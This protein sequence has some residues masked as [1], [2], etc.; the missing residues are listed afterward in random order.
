MISTMLAMVV[1]DT[2]PLSPPQ[3]DPSSSPSSLSDS[4][5]LSLLMFF[6]SFLL[7]FAGQK[8]LRPSLTTASTLLAAYTT[9]LLLLAYPLS[10]PSSLS[11]LLV[12]S[13]GLAGAVASL[14]LVEIGIILMGI[15]FGL[16]M[17]SLSYHLFHQW[18]AIQDH[19]EVIRLL[20]MI[21]LALASAMVS[22]FCLRPVLKFITAFIGSYF[23]VASIS[24]FLYRI[25]LFPLESF[26]PEHFFSSPSNFQCLHGDT[27]VLSICYGYGVVWVIL[28]VTGLVFQCSE[29]R[30]KYDQYEDIRLIQ[31]RHRERNNEREALAEERL[32]LMVE[33][34]RKGQNQYG[35]N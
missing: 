32:G 25:G 22:L 8:L 23:M 29:N 33:A 31:D 26:I 3:T 20:Y 10:I 35:A 24:H 30:I 4:D 2:A 27:T 5:F 18:A 6:T 9:H 21:C 1:T 16:I 12:F 28:F 34:R 15:L 13:A 14:I 17:A 7:L 19:E 11:Y